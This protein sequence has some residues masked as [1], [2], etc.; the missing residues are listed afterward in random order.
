METRPEKWSLKSLTMSEWNRLKNCGGQMLADAPTEAVAIYNR[1]RQGERQSRYR[2]EIGFACLCMRCL[3]DSNV[4]HTLPFPALAG[5]I[6]RDKRSSKTVRNRALDILDDAWS[7]D[8]FLLREIYSLAQEMRKKN[9]YVV[10]DFNELADLI[11]GWG[12]RGV[13]RLWL[14][15]V[16]C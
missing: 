14:S 2:E 7:E 13:K 9:G 4:T 6:Y 3:W 11:A 12:T 8:G 15:K 1:V 16:I 10:P 5:E